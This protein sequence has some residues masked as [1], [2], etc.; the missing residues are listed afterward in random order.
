MNHGVT[1]LNVAVDVIS[2]RPESLWTSKQPGMRTSA[3][4]MTGWMKE[5]SSCWFSSVIPDLASVTMRVLQQPR[6]C[7]RCLP[8]ASTGRQCTRARAYVSRR[9]LCVLL[10]ASALSLAPAQAFEEAP[11]GFY[12]HS[13][14]LDGYAFAY[15]DS[16]IIVTTSGNDV[17]Y[18]NSRVADENVFVDIS[19]PSSSKYESVKDLGTPEDASKR[20]EEQFLT[21][22][23]STRLGVKREIEPVF[24]RSR[25]GMSTL[26]VSCIW[27]KP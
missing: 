16:W 17:F 12:R 14:R 4:Y 27:Q 10:S 15:P 8:R 7:S 9:E 20:L 1:R 24:A 19:S 22:L 11:A 26:K 3:D 13:D 23:M 6:P 21:E 2:G 18:R 5:C 25:T